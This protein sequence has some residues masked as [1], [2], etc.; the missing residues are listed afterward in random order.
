V[1]D[2]AP[3]PLSGF[4]VEYLPIFNGEEKTGLG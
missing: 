3:L 2:A 1:L 4:A